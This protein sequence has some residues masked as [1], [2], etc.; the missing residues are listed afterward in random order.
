[1]DASTWLPYLLGGG[2]IGGFIAAL[3]WGRQDARDS[4]DAASSNTTTAMTLRNEVIAENA[5]LKL[6]LAALHLENLRLLA[7]M[8]QAGIDPGPPVSR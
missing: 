1:M 6:E 8:R 4:V 7:L 2:A 3:R 5:K